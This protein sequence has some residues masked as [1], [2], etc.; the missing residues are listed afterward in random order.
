MQGNPPLP[1]Y[2]HTRIIRVTDI[3]RV[4]CIVRMQGNSP[5]PAY[6]RTRIIRVPDIIRVPFIVRMQDTRTLPLPAYVH[7]RIIRLPYIIRMPYTTRLQDNL[8]LPA[9]THN[10]IIK[11][12]YIY[13]HTHRTWALPQ[14]MGH[15]NHTNRTRG[16]PQNMGHI[17]MIRML[18]NHTHTGHELCHITWAIHVYRTCA[19][20][21][22]LGCYIITY[23]QNISLFDMH[24]KNLY[25]HTHTGHEPIRHACSNA[26]S[27]LTHRTWAYL[28]SMLKCY[29]LTYTHDMSLFDSHVRMIHY[30]TSCVISHTQDVS[31]L[32]THR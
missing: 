10:R 16:L 11:M 22:S 14:N 12:Q 5:L 25:N 9:Y 3:I 19:I 13:I 28:T 29:I 32:D 27:S 8:P 24:V 30:L 23:T 21:V 6:F 18:H 4:P 1:A 15:T 26:V 7:T 31:L 2:F 17:S 20:H